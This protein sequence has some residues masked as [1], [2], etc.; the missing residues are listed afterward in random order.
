MKIQ[1]LK[2]TH[3]EFLKNSIE[4]LCDFRKS[5]HKISDD[6]KQGAQKKNSYHRF[7]EVLWD[8]VEN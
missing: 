4:M 8:Y 5:F 3:Q 2:Q 1:S 6:G 7:E